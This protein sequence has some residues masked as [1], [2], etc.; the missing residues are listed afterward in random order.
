M[1]TTT[2]PTTTPAVDPREDELR[3]AAARV[4]SLE[5]ELVTARGDRDRLIVALVRPNGDLPERR[6]AELGDVSNAHVSKV[7]SG[8]YGGQARRGRR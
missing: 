4:A 7:K 5:A 8:V 1:S 2:E 3:A 6:V